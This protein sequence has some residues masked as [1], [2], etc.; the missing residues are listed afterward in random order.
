ML[1]TLKKML[2]SK[3]ALATFAGTV[4]AFLMRFGLDVDPADIMATLSPVISYIVGQGI[5]DNGQRDCK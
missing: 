1:D 3:K 4:S 2:S 5:A